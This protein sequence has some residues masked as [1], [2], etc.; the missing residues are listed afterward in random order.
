MP[1]KLILQPVNSHSGRLTYLE[2]LPAITVPNFWQAEPGAKI[3]WNE[4]GDPAAASGVLMYYHGWPSSR[5]Q[6]RV[7]HHLAIARG[8]RVIA[9]DRPG[10]G[11][12]SFVH[13]RILKD[14]GALIAEFADAHGIDRFAQLAVSGGGPYVLPVVD[15]MPDRVAGSA[16]L[17]G[18]V[19]LGAGHS[20]RGLR[21]L[22]RL[23]IPLR[24]LPSA[25]LTPGLRIGGKVA[26]LPLNRPPLS[27]LVRTLPKEDRAVLL[28]NPRSVPAF[29]ASFQEGA[30]QG[31]RGI[32]ADAEVYLQ[33]WKIDLAS[34][35]GEIRY[36]HGAQDRNI[37]L[38][39]ARQLVSK[40]PI[41]TIEEDPHQ[42]HF[43]IALNRAPEVMDY[44]AECLRTP[45][46]R[47]KSPLEG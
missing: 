14:W 34:L 5:L 30:R 2:D 27:W 8:I 13:G 28:Q 45:A 47:A 42:G 7:L 44:L 36:W 31:W 25:L 10:V 4:Y 38:G 32:R 29:V 43:S 39:L 46:P 22:Y 37:P 17:C 33:D 3:A 21:P 6:A 1:G 20:R 41:A 16:V 40:I 19:P 35:R 24:K 12:S 9:L 11:Q 26:D 23:L 15:Q 18:A